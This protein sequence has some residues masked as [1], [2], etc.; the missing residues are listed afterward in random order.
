[1][2]FLS[3]QLIIGSESVLD[4]ACFYDQMIFTLY[5]ALLSGIVVIISKGGNCGR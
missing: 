2:T 4:I 1:M 3:I 5:T